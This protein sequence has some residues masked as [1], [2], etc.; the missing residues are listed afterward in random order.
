MSGRRQVKRMKWMMKFDPRRCQ[1]V[2]GLLL[3]SLLF[4]AV[5][6]LARAATAGV[7]PVPE[8][9][10]LFSSE[11]RPLLSRYCFA[12]HGPDNHERQADLRLDTSDG[13][14]SILDSDAS[15]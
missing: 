7:Q 13:L 9:P 12:C 6:G 14:K 5:C 15:S 8:Q 4:S 3:L 10:P 11:I 1:F 2:R